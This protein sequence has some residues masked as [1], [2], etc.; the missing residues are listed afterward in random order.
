MALTLHNLPKTHS[1]ARNP[2]LLEVETDNYLQTAGVPYILTV[3]EVPPKV[4]GN[5]ITLQVGSR[6][7]MITFATTPDPEKFEVRPYTNG[8]TFASFLSDMNALPILGD[9]YTASGTYGSPS[10]IS[11]TLNN[12]DNRDNL[13]TVVNWTNSTNSISTGG[14]ANAY[15]PNFRLVANVYKQEDESDRRSL[16]L[17]HQ[18]DGIPDKVSNRVKF[19]LSSAFASLNV[20]V[21]SGA[22]ETGINTCTESHCHYWVELAEKYGESPISYTREMIGYAANYPSVIGGGMTWK[23]W[24]D[25]VVNDD[26]FTDTARKFFTNK[27]VIT[28]RPNMPQWLHWYHDDFASNIEVDVVA[29][30]SDNTTDTMTAGPYVKAKGVQRIAVGYTQL[31]IPGN[32]TIPAGHVVSSYTVKVRIGSTTVSE[33]K[34]YKVDHMAAEEHYLV[35]ENM[36]MGL[37]TM[38]CRGELVRGMKAET[39]DAEGVALPDYSNTNG[40]LQQYGT[41]GRD[42]MSLSTGFLNPAE[43]EQ[44]R[45]LI[46]ADNIWYVEGTKL[47]RVT[48]DRAAFET[49]YGTVMPESGVVLG[50]ML[51]N[52]R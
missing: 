39:N 13:L 21:P 32:V 46:L 7:I 14:V 41:V 22:N 19:D 16:A 45:E 37:D 23:D 12:P 11:F 10:I 35:Y 33:T 9:Y 27:A 17:L 1:A 28:T 36:W 48:L 44:L 49:M 5:T 51:G 25:D 15:R 6:Q 31:D 4:A 2:M 3:L 34:T 29:T 24:D 50:L 43:M 52:Y 42:V 38:H 26:Y 8:P 18:L 47:L 40:P 30:F 20:D